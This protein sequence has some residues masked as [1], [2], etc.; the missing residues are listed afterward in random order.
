MHSVVIDI[1]VD[2]AASC[3]CIVSFEGS[4]NVSTNLFSEAS[5]E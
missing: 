1:R 2:Q 4:A 3:I 5:K